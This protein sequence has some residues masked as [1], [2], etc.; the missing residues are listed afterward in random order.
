MVQDFP[1]KS[2]DSAG[3]TSEQDKTVGRHF[4][5]AVSL[6]YRA[7]RVSTANCIVLLLWFENFADPNPIEDVYCSIIRRVRIGE[8]ISSI[9][10]RFRHT[11]FQV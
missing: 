3:Q 2:R 9:L 11:V 4:H 1:H 5:L 8:E 6:C 10:W 7:K